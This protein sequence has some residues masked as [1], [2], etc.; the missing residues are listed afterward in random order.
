[1]LEQR[2]G[3]IVTT[4]VCVCMIGGGAA[5]KCVHR[6]CAHTL[7]VCMLLC[8]MY[9]THVHGTAYKWAYVHNVFIAS[10]ILSHT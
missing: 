10:Y 8:I 2:R 4:N 6:Q 1:M 3:E 7:Y 5:Y 9:N